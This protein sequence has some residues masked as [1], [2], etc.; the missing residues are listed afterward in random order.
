[1][2]AEEAGIRNASS[3]RQ[4]VILCVCGD[5]SDR[6][7][8]QFDFDLALGPA[9][10]ADLDQTIIRAA[11]MRHAPVVRMVSQESQYLHFSY[12]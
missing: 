2:Y 10:V 11:G 12:L 4:V 8:S 6:R 7:W 9:L 3:G 1:L 5:I